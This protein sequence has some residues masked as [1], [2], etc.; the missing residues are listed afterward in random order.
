MKHQH[1][2]KHIFSHSDVYK[3]LCENL[4]EKIDSESCRRIK[5]HIQGCEHCSAMLDSLKKTVYLYRKYPTPKIPSKIKSELF[6]VIR[7]ENEK[8]KK[9]KDC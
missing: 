8:S 4:D 3:H 1:T 5:A 2:K 6:A 7:L 9:P